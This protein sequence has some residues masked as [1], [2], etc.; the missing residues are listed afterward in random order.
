VNVLKGKVA[1]GMKSGFIRSSLVVFQFMI[2][3]FLVIG[4][5]TVQKQLS[6]IQN[7]K[8]GFK[9]DQI[10]VLHNV[11]LL[12]TQKEALKNELLKSPLITNASSS[13]FLPISGWARND[14]S[15]W[16]EGSQPTQDNMISMQFWR[17][18]GDYIP[19]MGMEIKVGRNF[20]RE[21]PSDSTGIIINEAAAKRFGFIDPIGEKVSTFD[22]HNGAIDNS[23]LLTYTVIGVVN[24]FHF[25]SLK[26]NITPLCM[27][28]G[29]SSWSMPIRFESKNTKE[30]IE[31]VEKTWKLLA[32]AQPFEYTFLDD[33]FGN[34][35]SSEQRLGSVFGI[36]ATLAI[37]IAC[38]GLFALTSFTAEQRTK[39]IGIRKVLGASVSGIVFLLSREFGKLIL[40]AFLLAAP[41]AWYAVNWWLKNYTYK[42]EVGVAIY[43]MAGA[44]AFIVA[45]LTMGYQSIKAATSNPVQSLRSE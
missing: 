3:I 10:I 12:G 28:L 37:I 2:S 32:G 39:E 16:P 8:L 21:F 22:Y 23:K 40:I 19:T 24:D 6:F 34:M 41:V 26:Q 17:V 38:L 5:I 35:Y 44:F 45:W 1:L 18:D 9:K 11:E 20:S 36:F 4:T 31:H 13:G 15:F 14:N 25:E 7:K 30:V 42:V 29:E 33:A 27:T 43:L